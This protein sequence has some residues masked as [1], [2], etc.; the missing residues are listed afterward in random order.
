[1][2]GQQATAWTNSAS[3]VSGRVEPRLWTPPLREL[4]RQTSYGFDL[5]DFA[6][7]IGWPLDEWQKWLAIH[8]GELLPDG[9]PRFRQVVILVAR[10]NGKSVFC[11]I[12]T[13]YWMFLETVPLVFGINST[14]DTAKESW[15]NVIQMAEGIELLAEELPARHINKVIGEEAFWNVHGSRYRFGAPNSAAGRSLTVDRAIIDELRQHKTRDAWDALIPTMNAVRDAQAV[16]ITNEGDESAIV[17][18]ELTESAETYIAT[19]EG[20][21]R[22]GMFSWSAPMGAAPDDLEALS[23]ANPDLGNRIQPDVLL[24]QGIQAKMAGGETLARFRIEMMCQR[25]MLL[26]AAIEPLS[27]KACAGRIED[28]AK[29]REKVALAFDVSLDG[30]HA[31]LCAAAL[32]DGVVHVD[33]VKAWEGYGCTRAMR[34]DLPEI[35]AKVKPVS[36]GWFPAGPAASVAAAIGTTVF[37]RRVSVEEIRGDKS[38]ACMGLAEVV[39]AEQ[40]LHGNDP[41]L[42]VHVGQTQ[43]LPQ[44]DAWVFTRR[45]S[46]PVD[47]SYALAGAVHLARSLK[48][49]PK[50]VVG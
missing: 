32:I 5:I 25:V 20:D 17:L 8:I 31:T 26:D 2:S 35:V 50:L 39:T 37:P 36:L 21:P 7:A 12:L 3:A 10:Q 44:G 11:R 14:R 34:R 18:H 40:L 23:Y 29:H 47:A 43:R 45:G 41:L 9:R 6:E 24:G 22:L 46:G 27:W 13:L 16:I 28:L 49:R 48:P 19:G 38:A 33:V 30:Q 42:N 1:M 4:T 15:K